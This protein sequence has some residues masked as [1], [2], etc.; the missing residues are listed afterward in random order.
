MF[1]L[2]LERQVFKSALQIDRLA[3]CCD[4]VVSSSIRMHMMEK[5]FFLESW[6]LDFFKSKSLYTFYILKRKR[7]FLNDWIPF[8]IDVDAEAKSFQFHS[9]GSLNIRYSASPLCILLHIEKKEKK[10]NTRRIYK[11]AMNEINSRKVPLNIISAS[12]F[13]I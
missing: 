13:F 9:S 3:P 4:I 8:C 12:L 10:K 5:L 11:R 6:V 7:S 1:L 2:R